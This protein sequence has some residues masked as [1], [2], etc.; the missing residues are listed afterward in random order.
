[1][2]PRALVDTACRPW[3]C[4]GNELGSKRRGAE[5]GA[6]LLIV[7]LVLFAGATARADEPF[8][9]PSGGQSEE[10]LEQD[11]YE[12]YA[13]AKQNSGFDPMQP[14]PSTTQVVEQRR[15]GVVKGALGGAALGAIIGD[16]SK[17]TGRGAAAGALFGGVHQSSQ[18]RR[19]Q[20][21]AQQRAQQQANAYAAQ[22]ADYIRAYAACLE[23]RNYTVK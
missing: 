9:Y 16:S 4:L 20:E 1:M 6:R 13:W 10:Q 18:N 7:G 11:K 2:G 21:A 3:L 14:P 8:I 23:G 5:M 19:A 12:C 17:A 22:R 15:G